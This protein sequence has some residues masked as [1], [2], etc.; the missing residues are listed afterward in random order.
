MTANAAV[1]IAEISARPQHMQQRAQE[2]VGEVRRHVPFD[3][4]WVALIEPGGMKYT[5]LASTD[6]DDQT[7]GYLSGPRMAQDIELTGANRARPP[8]SASDLPYSLAEL[9]TWAECL[10]PAGL[11][12]TLSVALYERGGRHVGFLTLLLQRPDPPP[13][14]IRRQ[15]ARLLPG[16]A[17]AIDP[18]R[19]TATSA[20]LVRSASAGVVLMPERGVVRIPGLPDD[21]LVAADS[22]LIEVARGAISDGFEYSTFL[23]P[24]GGRHA[25]G[26]H[27]RVTVMSGDQNLKG[28]LAGIVVLSPAEQLHGLTPRE[29]E[30]LGLL[31]DGCSNQEIARALFVAPRTVA[32]HLEHILCK[33]HAGSRTLAA[34]RAE[35]AGLYVPPARADGQ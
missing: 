9:Q 22:D 11:N 3:A 28:V 17:S 7:V 33:L 2:L 18:V 12:E 24:R 15:L 14:S 5:S 16:L 32:A 13:D 6:L 31:I 29:L 19:S 4:S 21:A 23:W 20:L 34:V 10:L 27:V 26:G 25:P 1:R 8:L 30:V 35:R